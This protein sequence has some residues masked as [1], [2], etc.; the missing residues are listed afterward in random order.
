MTLDH[1]KAG[2]SVVIVSWNAASVIEGC[3]ESLIGNPPE[4]PFEILVLD[5]ASADSS[6]DKARRFPPTG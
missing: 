4:R 6:L 3:L 2:L 5:N 1:Q